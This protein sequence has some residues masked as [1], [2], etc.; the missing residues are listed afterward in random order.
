[1][2]RNS[3]AFRLVMSSAIVS[4][5]L[6]VSAALLLANLFQ[7]ALE[8]NFD[9]RLRAVLDGL[10][11]NVTVSDTATPAMESELADARFSLPLSGWYWQIMRADGKGDDLASESLLEQR[12]K[13]SAGDLAIRDADGVAHFY[14][15]DK[16]GVRLRVIEQ[17]YKLFDQASEFSFL[18]AG[19]YD[20]LKAESQAF[21]RALIIILSLLGIGLLVAILVQVRFGLRPLAAMQERL[22]AIREGRAEKLEGTYPEEIQ[23]VAVELNLLIQSNSEIVDRARTQV[24]NLAHALKTP[25]SVLTNEAKLQPGPLASKVSEQTGVMR[26][27]VSLYLDRARRAARAQTLGSVTE[28]EAVLASLARTLERIHHD[29]GVTIALRCEKDLKFRGEKQDLEEMAGNLL[30]NACKWSK[31]RVTVTAQGAPSP[32]G[33]PGLL[34]EGDDDGP[35]LPEERRAEALKRGRRLD[36]TKPGSGLG[37]SIVAE[38]AAMYN[39]TVGLDRSELGGLLVRLRLPAVA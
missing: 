14:L 26:D 27:Q 11:A 23:P 8:R 32:D 34:I 15:T 3:L 18:V 13:P 35:G 24:G 10:L 1:M 6:L 19:N 28:A 5:I 4:V 39:G 7:T 2:R 31:R 25:L 22:T 12:L 36:E 37:L 29:K 21:H 38:T 17:R 9:A 33:W 30:D 16:A 20:E